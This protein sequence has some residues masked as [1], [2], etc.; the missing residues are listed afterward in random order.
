MRRE[1]LPL[2]RLEAAIAGWTREL[3]HGR[4]F[5]VLRG[6]PV[7]AWGA[8]DA[9]LVSWGLGLHLGH[10]GAQNADSD[11]LDHV[12]HTCEDAPKPFVRRHLTAR[13]LGFP[14]DTTDA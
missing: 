10:P 3:T 6:L 14:S 5:L 2:P 4:G 1:D 9:A 12:V 13:A 8:D 7:D 11:L